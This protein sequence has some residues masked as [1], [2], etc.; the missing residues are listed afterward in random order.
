LTRLPFLN[1]NRLMA[2]RR[3]PYCKAIIDEGSEYCSNCGTQLLFPED[4]Y[5]HE[6]IPGDKVVEEETPEVNKPKKGGGSSRGRKKKEE[7]PEPEKQED[8]EEDVEF[9]PM[10]EEEAERVE[11]EE[12][13]KSPE[14]E[15]DEFFVE[16]QEPA[17]GT[18]DLE[19]VIDPE[20]KE[21]AEI[22]KFLKSLKEDRDEWDGEIPPTDELPPWAE[23]IKDEK[24]DEMPFVD[25]GSV[26]EDQEF[27]EPKE[28]LPLEE[29]EIA[30]E[31]PIDEELPVEG[32]P[33]VEEEKEEME[34]ILKPRGLTPE[35][36]VPEV[37]IPEEEES[38]EGIIEEEAAEEV[39]AEEEIVEE[40]II[41]VDKPEEELIEEKTPEE[42]AS[43]PDTG[44]GLPEGVEQEKL[45]F[46]DT[47][48]GEFDEE[49]KSSPSRLSTWFKSRAF[50]VLFIAAFWIVALH[51]ASR[52]LS[53][54]LFKL[55]SVS[56]LPAVAFYLAL[57]AVYL[58]LFFLFLGQTLGDHLF[59]YEE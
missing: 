16:P 2:I 38:E 34:E 28:A 56:A 17:F 39:I 45:P 58:F 46:V 44:M 12:V 15:R 47:S 27:E 11:E 23:K 10:E 18:E 43:M 4:E 32:S 52:M 26:E 29:K 3:C 5:I 22:E 51:I 20:E 30:E 24:P 36:E 7:E 8:V 48:T 31:Q 33:S 53:T 37:Q 59:P 57:L 35:D 9:E 42:E 49:E 1:I 50:D 13:Q 41:E 54:N 55:I 14:A 40:E 25:T 21:K 19:K 6:D